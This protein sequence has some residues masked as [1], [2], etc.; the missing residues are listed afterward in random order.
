MKKLKVSSVLPGGW[1]SSLYSYP[2]LRVLH[3]EFLGL[4]VPGLKA[5]VPMSG[6]SVNVQNAVSSVPSFPVFEMVFVPSSMGQLGETIYVGI[7]VTAVQNP[8]SPTPN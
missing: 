6:R 4:S 5:M 1:K 3:F 8:F 7:S 2:P